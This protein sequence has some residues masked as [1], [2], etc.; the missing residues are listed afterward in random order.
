[1][2]HSSKIILSYLSDAVPQFILHLEQAALA[3]PPWLPYLF[4][5]QEGGAS[6]AEM[7]ILGIFAVMTSCRSMTRKN[8]LKTSISSYDRLGVRFDQLTIPMFTFLNSWELRFSSY[9]KFNT[10]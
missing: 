8:C 3:P 4:L 2:S 1:M 5:E 6:P 10:Y 7:T 9:L